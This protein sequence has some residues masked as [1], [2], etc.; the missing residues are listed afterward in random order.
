MYARCAWALILEEIF[1][2]FLRVP[3]LW[4]VMLHSDWNVEVIRWE[5]SLPAVAGFSSATT[6]AASV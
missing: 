6:P 1:P 5:I 4:R 3:A 2:A